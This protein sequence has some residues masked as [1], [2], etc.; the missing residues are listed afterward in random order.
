VSPRWRS[1]TIGSALDAIGNTPI[2]KL[3]K[4]VPPGNGDVVVKLDRFEALSSNA[5]AEEKTRAMRAFGGDVTLLHSE[6]GKIAPEL[7]ESFKQEIAQRAAE[8]DT[9]YTD[10]LN[11]RW[12]YLAHCT[13]PAAVRVLPHWNPPNRQ[14]SPRE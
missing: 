3:R 4:V 9:F 7:F 13:R 2:A 1:T 8:P 11:C 5:F 6:G 12:G 10:R 14:R